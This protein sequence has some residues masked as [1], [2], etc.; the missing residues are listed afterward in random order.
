MAVIALEGMHF[1]GHHGFYEEERI[2]G[3][4]FILDVYVDAETSMAAVSDDLYSTVNYETVYFICR[5]EMKKP[6]KLLEAIAQRISNRINSV[7]DGIS[8][9]KVRVRKLAPPLGAKVRSAYVEVSSGTLSGGGGGGFSSG[10]MQ[11][12]EGGDDN[13]DFFN[14]FLF[15]K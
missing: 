12:D 2:I 1:F 8:G 13:F 4:N 10:F 3:N 5:T 15:W 11:D 9:V 14:F 7:F 6:T